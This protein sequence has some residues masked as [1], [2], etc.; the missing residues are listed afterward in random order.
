MEAVRE[1]P[2]SFLP[3][4]FLVLWV[5]SVCLLQDSASN[6]ESLVPRLVGFY[7]YCLP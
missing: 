7:F 5:V 2:A 3:G 6:R 1:A 4:G